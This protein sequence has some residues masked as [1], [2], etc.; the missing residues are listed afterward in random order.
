MVQARLTTKV[1]EA[2][3]LGLTLTLH[4]PQESLAQTFL[5]GPQE[6]VV[7]KAQRE[8]VGLRTWPDG[9]LGV[10]GRS[11]GKLVFFAANYGR[12]TKTVG[13]LDDPLADSIQPGLKLRHPKRVYNYA[14]GG[15]TYRDPAS[16]ALLLFYHGE[17]WPEGDF[18]R[19]YSVIGM[20]KSAD[21]GTS[22]TDLGEIL[23]AN[24]PIG[25]NSWPVDLGGAP[26]VIAGGYFYVYF[27]DWLPNAT[28][29][30]LAV[31][32]ARVDRV[33]EAALNRNTTV[34]W[35]KQYRRSW[36]EP[37]LGGRSSRLESQNNSCYWGHVAYNEALGRYLM[38]CSRWVTASDANL[39]IMS[40]TDGLSWS[41]RQ[42]IESAPGESLYPTIVGIGSDPQRTGDEFYVYYVYSI[43][44]GFE[45]W[46]DA[47]LARRQLMVR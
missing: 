4:A 13:T 46:S 39:E 43:A 44:A 29:N 2:L 7:S 31:A 40:S 42:T 36:S 21:G 45:R 33:L 6:T 11:D 38:V 24:V 27:R 10:L 15:P 22:W 37:G 41:A 16:G 1:S 28:T 12:I 19:Y 9:S 23:R 32:R 34:P 18:T 35:R 5:V 25:K 26:F 30:E 47:F 17:L 8:A 20:A 14:A 3:V